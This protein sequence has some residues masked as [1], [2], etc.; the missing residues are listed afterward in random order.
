VSRDCLCAARREGFLFFFIFCFDI[1]TRSVS[2][3]SPAGESFFYKS[4]IG[5]YQLRAANIFFIGP[6]GV[7]FAQRFFIG[8]QGTPLYKMKTARN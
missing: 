4:A 8:P 1:A 3:I 5:F 6:Q 7:S 2:F